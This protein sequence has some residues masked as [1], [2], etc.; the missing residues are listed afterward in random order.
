LTQVRSLDVLRQQ[1]CADTRTTASTKAIEAAKAVLARAKLEAPEVKQQ[2]APPEH[3]KD[4]ASAALDDAALSSSQEAKP[5]AVQPE[6][7]EED[8]TWDSDVLTRAVAAAE[9]LASRL[10][11]TRK[12]RQARRVTRAR[13]RSTPEEKAAT[14]PPSD[15]PVTFAVR[16]HVPFG[17]RIA[18]VGSSAALGAW[19]VDRA[20]SMAW[21]PGDVWRSPPVML[22]VNSAHAYK[23]V[24]LEPNSAETWQPGPNQ[25][26]VVDRQDMPSIAVTD[27]WSGSP[28][29]ASIASGPNRERRAA[30]ERLDDS[31]RRMHAGLVMAQKLAADAYA[32]L[33]CTQA[34]VT[35]LREEV[36]DHQAA[37]QSVR[38]QAQQ[39]RAAL[40][41]QLGAFKEAVQGVRQQLHDRLQGH[42]AEGGRRDDQAR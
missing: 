1:H 42:S 17:S 7:A 5:Q 34:V 19:H 35:A 16:K 32:E 2:V 18:I 25:N 27:S 23:Y 39:H 40:A 36:R 10:E 20:V 33:V 9:A 26:L 28:G 8:A 29:G 31:V 14:P 24:I 15:V 12:P 11:S 41:Q 21:S 3:D 38:R 13:S 4:D 6:H 37:L 22:S 30:D